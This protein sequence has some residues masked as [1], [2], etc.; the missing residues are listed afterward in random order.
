MQL[1]L[2]VSVFGTSFTTVPEHHAAGQ[3]WPAGLS[4]GST[5]PYSTWILWLSAGMELERERERGRERE[6]ERERETEREKEREKKRKTKGEWEGGAGTQ[7][8]QSKVGGNVKSGVY[9]DGIGT[10]GSQ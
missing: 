7:E 8:Q 2:F 10:P 3:G 9:M 6:R 5:Y 4:K 1:L